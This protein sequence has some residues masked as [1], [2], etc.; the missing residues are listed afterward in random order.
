MPEE[1]KNQVSQDEKIMGVLAYIWA[2]CLLPLLGKKDSEFC[3]FHAK[4][5]LV[6]FVA[7]FAVMF[8]G[9]IPVIGW[10]VIL[11]VGWFLIAAASL[12]GLLNAWQGKKWEI[13]FLG[14]YAKKIN[15]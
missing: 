2:L 3:Q 6:L 7:S 15:L 1:N 5:G 14:V 13:P 12:L 4:Q 8:L 10:F 11:P 9:M